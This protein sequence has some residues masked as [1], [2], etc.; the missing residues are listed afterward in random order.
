MR[1]SALF[2]PWG[3]ST[4]CRDLLQKES[5]LGARKVR[6]ERFFAQHPYCCFCGGANPA[7]TEDH[8]P[9]RSLFYK[10][11]W[12]EGYV[13]PACEACNRNS[14]EDE[15]IMGF[16]VRVTVLPV[17]VEQRRERLKTIEGIK[18]RYPDFFQGFQ[19]FSR[20]ETRRRAQAI[21]GLEKFG[22]EPT[23]IVMVGM[24]QLAMD[25]AT[26]YGEKLGK[27]LHYF[28]TQE[29]LPAGGST[30][31]WVMTNAVSPL[32]DIPQELMGPLT[33]APMAQ[34]VRGANQLDSQFS[35]RYLIVEN[36]AATCFL[37]TLGAS[38]TVLMTAFRDGADGPTLAQ[39]EN[40]RDFVN[41]AALPAPQ[42]EL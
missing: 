1:P 7:T 10:R 39:Q 42:T 2:G 12:P 31:A 3:V 37:V 14:A 41:V 30:W 35:Y 25:V 13:F 17:D 15:L 28:H 26:R 16:L 40:L 24:P 8:L 34:I 6:R 20:N 36:G 11:G 4:I 21:G 5:N 38:M 23:N 27:A 18:A 32:L 33:A 9:A 19:K 29:I 22:V